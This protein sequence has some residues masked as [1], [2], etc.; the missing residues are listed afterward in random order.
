VKVDAEG[1]AIVEWEFDIGEKEGDVEL[2]WPVGYGK[3]PL[4]T[5]DAELTEIVS[6]RLSGL[7]L[8]IYPWPLPSEWCRTRYQFAKDG[9]TKG[10]NCTR[11]F[12]STR[13]KIFPI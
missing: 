5:I 11:A 13:G 7:L 9:N 1:K 12:G 2:W 10:T 6:L 8:L 4:Y 3:Q